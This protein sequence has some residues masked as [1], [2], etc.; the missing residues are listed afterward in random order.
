V[1][2]STPIPVATPEIDSTLQ[3]LFIGNSFTFFNNLPGMFAELAQSGGYEVEVGM[4]AHG[5]W[6]CDDHSKSS[7]TLNMIAQG[8]WDF[9]VLQEKSRYPALAD[10][11]AEKMYPAIRLLDESIR[12]NGA[13]TVLFMTWANKNGLLEHG[14][15]DYFAMQEEVQVGYLEIANELDAMVAPV[16][17]AWQNAML[18]DSQFNLWGGDGIHPNA[19]GTY[20]AAL[21]FY[22]TLLQQSPEGVSYHAGLSEDVAQFLQK[23]AAETIFVFA[24]QR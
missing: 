17:V 21:V 18:Q 19:E 22:A 2:A 13:T 11:R 9:V 4:S 24:Q 6:S 7:E 14:Y 12:E 3:I 10:Q 8:D 15:Q 20:L 23:I 5:G 16:G 1:A